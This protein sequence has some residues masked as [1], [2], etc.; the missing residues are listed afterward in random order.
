MSP[1]GEDRR[2]QHESARASPPRLVIAIGNASRGDDA[3]GPLL[4]QALR[5]E[6]WFDGEAAE[7]IEVSQLQVEDALELAGR[8]AVLFIDAERLPDRAAGI[9]DDGDDGIGAPVGV[10][11]RTVTNAAAPLFSHALEPGALLDVHTRGLGRAP[12][13][14]WV[15][16]IAGAG[17]ELG[18]PL[19]AMARARLPVALALARAWLRPPAR[20]AAPD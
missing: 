3:V 11:L 9:G 10:R 12:P 15:L 19:S 20:A 7:L 8:E 4:A 6:G 1:S 5:E 2:A 17:F 16:A 13:A 14:A 18:A